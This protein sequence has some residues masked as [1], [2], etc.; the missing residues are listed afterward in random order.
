ME[1]RKAWRLLRSKAGIENREYKAQRAILADVDAGKISKEDLFAHAGELL[2]TRMPRPAGH[3]PA[4]PK[5]AA[6]A[7]AGVATP[8]PAQRPAADEQPA[9]G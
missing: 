2:K 7:A 4:E 6:P 5:P 8:P 1:R 9:A 3:K